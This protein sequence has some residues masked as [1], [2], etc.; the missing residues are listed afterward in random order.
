MSL[1]FAV[2]NLIHCRRVRRRD[3]SAKGRP[4]T[5]GCPPYEILPIILRFRWETP[6]P[7]ESGK[8]H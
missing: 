3:L 5:K 6:N 8:F 4:S 1:Y 7:V 2:I